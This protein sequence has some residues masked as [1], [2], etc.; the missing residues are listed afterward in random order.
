MFLLRYCICFSP[1]PLHLFSWKEDT[2]KIRELNSSLSLLFS[3]TP[4]LG[5]VSGSEC[6]IQ[7]C[8][9]LLFMFGWELTRC[10]SLW[11]NHHLLIVIAR[12][13]P[14]AWKVFSMMY[15]KNCSLTFL[16]KNKSFYFGSDFFFFNTSPHA[17]CLWI[18]LLLIPSLSESI[19]LWAFWVFSLLSEKVAS[20]LCP[21]ALCPSSAVWHFGGERA[22]L[23]SPTHWV[24]SPL[25]FYLSDILPFSHQSK[26][27]LGKKDNA[28][29]CRCSENQ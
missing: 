19:W 4:N 7:S 14:K 22:C 29:Y 1:V 13:K 10:P 17:E 12:Q 21:C 8:K 20:L 27:S 2:A 24:S 5:F 28:E 23:R 26:L 25:F 15:S 16:N 9:G 11:N 3:L 18:A 6:P